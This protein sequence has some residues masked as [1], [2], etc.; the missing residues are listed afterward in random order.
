[1]KFDAVMLIRPNE[2][3]RS[4]G[5]GGQVIRIVDARCDGRVVYQR[6]AGVPD[7]ALRQE[8][9]IEQDQL[10]E[11]FEP[12]GVSDLGAGNSIALNKD[13]QVVMDHILA[14]MEGIQA[15]GLR[16][17][18]TELTIH[19]HGLQSFVSQHMLGRLPGGTWSDWFE[20]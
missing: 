14:A 19:V 6:T 12:T 2:L 1:M 9:T 8:H 15:W 17:N 13:E 10:R 3:W 7:Y 11:A 18:E 4:K 5:D 16:A 20:R